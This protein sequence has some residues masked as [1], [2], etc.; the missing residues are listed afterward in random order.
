[1]SENPISYELSDG[2]ATITIDRPEAMNAING[3]V[4]E[5]LWAAFRRF[6]TDGVLLHIDAGLQYRIT[7]GTG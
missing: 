3:A 7:S 2:I 4:R 1:M 6:V 5:G